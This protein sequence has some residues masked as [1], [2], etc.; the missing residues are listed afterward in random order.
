[1][2]RAPGRRPGPARPPINNV[3]VYVVDEHLSPVPLGA[4]GDDRRSPGSASAAATSTT[5]SAPRRRSWTDPH[6]PGRAALPERRLRP[7]A[8]RRQA[9]VP[10]PPRHPG[11]DLRASGSRSARSRTP[12]CGCPGVRDGAVVVAERPG[13]QQAPGGLLLRRRSRSTSTSCA[14]GWPR[15][16]PTTW[17]RPPSTGGSSCR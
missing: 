2:D 6:R 15:R 5:P 4:P 8:A 14:T 7:L 17:C 13:P 3:R 12:C 10:R 16:C 9:G 11:Q 1:M